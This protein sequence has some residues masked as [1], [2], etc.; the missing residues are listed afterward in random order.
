M[1]ISIFNMN[2]QGTQLTAHFEYLT[3][4]LD[5]GLQAELNTSNYWWVPNERKNSSKYLK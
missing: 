3:Y 5:V 2:D 1:G 4:W